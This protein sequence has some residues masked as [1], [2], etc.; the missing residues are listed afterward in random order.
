MQ[1]K[2]TGFRQRTRL[3]ELQYEHLKLGRAKADLGA[4]RAGMK[5]R[6]LNLSPQYNEI[7]QAIGSIEDL[8][9]QLETEIRFEQ[10]LVINAG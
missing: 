7:S 1:G 3:E 5:D 2:T 4:V 6:G 10:R 8:M 9:W